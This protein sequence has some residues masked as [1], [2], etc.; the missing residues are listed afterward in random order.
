LCL[1]LKMTWVGYWG[2]CRQ[3]RPPARARRGAR[4]PPPPTATP[5]AADKDVLH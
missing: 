5:P 3:Q 1:Y 4:P 2:M